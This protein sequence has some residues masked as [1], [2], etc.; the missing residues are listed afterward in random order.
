[1]PNPKIAS[2]NRRADRVEAELDRRDKAAMSAPFPFQ[3]NEGNSQ[4]PRAPIN[5]P[6]LSDAVQGALNTVGE[7]EKRLQ[8]I[9]GRLFGEALQ[10]PEMPAGN[11]L[12]TMAQELSTRLA[13]ATGLAATIY[14]RL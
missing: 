4:G 7:L 10:D 8:C 12:E 6:T 9:H 1:M 14:E 13:C 11:T 3:K 5:N 2:L